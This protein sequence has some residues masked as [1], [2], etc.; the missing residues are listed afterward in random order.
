MPEFETL[1]YTQTG[2]VVTLTL[3]RPERMNAW[4]RTMESEF[5]AALRHASKN[6]GVSCIVVTG[7]GR[8]FCA[9]ADIRA[10]KELE[11]QFDPDA[12]EA[13]N[14]DLSRTASPEVPVALAESKPVIAAIN[15]AAVG[16]GLTM[17][18]ACDIRVASDR[19]RFSARFVRVGL[20]PEC[21]GSRNLP[22]VAGIATALELALTGRILEPGD[23]LIPRLVNYLVPH[24]ELMPT[25]YRLAEEIASGP[26]GPVWLA[27]RVI[28]RDSLEQ[29]L[30][31]VVS[32]E[33]EL[34]A[35][36]RYKGAH[37]E[38]MSAFLEKRD[39]KWPDR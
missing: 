10:W 8:A 39:P 32:S 1:L 6:P 7:E 21:G 3:N 22:E 35:Q 31:R 23:P 37:R 2:R 36:L 13:L 4:T 33:T 30:R 11:E 25:A 5:I 15:G 9:G 27:K 19:A 28:R 12:I 38:A 16:I 26:T 24:E 34:F 14:T 17:A 20:I 29:D 18:M